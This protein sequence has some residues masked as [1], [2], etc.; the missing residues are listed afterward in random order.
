MDE[1]SRREVV[2]AG[3]AGLALALLGG[4]ANAMKDKE[5]RPLVVSGL[6]NLGPASDY[7]AGT[8]NTQ[9]L[10]TYG[11]VLANDSGTVIAIRPKCTH[12]GCIAKWDE[13]HRKFVCPCHG[14]EYNLLGEPIKGPAKQALPAVPT[15]KN[16]DGTLSVDLDRLYAMPGAKLPP[17]E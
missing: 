2:G 10:A 15:I 9:F 6:V 5:T 13:E 11:I 12:R 17:R 7:P 4:C 14:S 16:V 8:A 3:I 1:L